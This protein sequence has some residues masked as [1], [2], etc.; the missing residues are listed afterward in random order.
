LQSSAKGGTC[1]LRCIF[2]GEVDTW[3]VCRQV[4]SGAVRNHNAFGLGQACNGESDDVGA[5]ELQLLRELVDLADLDAAEPQG[6]VL[7]FGHVAMLLA[8]LCI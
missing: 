4:I 6:G 1:Y 8:A 7:H 5:I 2:V 3:V